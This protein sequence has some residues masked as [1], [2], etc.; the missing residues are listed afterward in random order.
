MYWQFRRQIMRHLSSP[1]L[2]LTGPAIALAAAPPRYAITDLGAVPTFA[3]IFGGRVNAD[4]IVLGV[5]TR[6][7]TM[8]NGGGEQ[9]ERSFLRTSGEQR[10]I[11]VINGNVHAWDLN[12]LGQV[13]GTTAYYCNSRAF[14]WHDGTWSLLPP[15]G[16]SSSWC[17]AVNDHGQ[18]VG[19]SY[20]D[21]SDWPYH[22]T[23]WQP[24]GSAIDLG[25]LGGSTGVSNA[26]AINNFGVVVGWTDYPARPHVAFRWQNGQMIALTGPGGAESRRPTVARDINDEGIV[27]GYADL[28]GDLNY[29]P[30]TWRNGAVDTLPLPSDRPIGQ[31]F[32]LNNAGDIIGRATA[33]L[34]E[35]EQYRAL[36]WR[37]G[38][39]IDLNSLIPSNSGWVL[40]DAAHISDSG[41]IVGRGLVN[42]ELHGFLLTPTLVATARE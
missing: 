30:L 33:A 28:S 21:E 14:V 1:I 20:I 16:G 27:A 23:L 4:G 5:A 18:V 39:V 31:A 40:T 3:Q 24:D 22:A 32:A 11:L 7:F 15:L 17:F 2:A 35:I 41:H 13:V 42:G 25:T 10:E 9:Q 12:A 36:L 19:G 6:S 34:Y 38:Q 37:H 26:A 8:P 29:E